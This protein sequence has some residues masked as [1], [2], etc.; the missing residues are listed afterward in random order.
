M[1][2]CSIFNN[3]EPSPLTTS[4]YANLNLFPSH[5]GDKSYKFSSNCK[6]KI[7]DSPQVRS[8]EPRD[9]IGTY[10]SDKFAS[11]TVK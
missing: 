2:K 11:M 6:Y 1:L 5:F 10:L 7:P 4:T 9:Y 8:T 3:G